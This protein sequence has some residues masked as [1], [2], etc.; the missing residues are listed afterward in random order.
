MTETSDAEFFASLPATRGS[1]GGLI[2]ST[3]GAVLLVRRAYRA[4][5]RWG[6][7]GGIMEHAESPLAACGR[8]IAEELG[9]PAHPLR[10]AVVD[11]MP[12]APPRTAALHWLFRVE[13]S[14]TDF[15]LPPEELSAWEWVPP[16]RLAAYLSTGAARRMAAA[17]RVDDRGSGPVYLENGHPVLAQER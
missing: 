17:V 8:E 7:P 2:R 12:P 11:W 3:T 10:L 16:E 14:S 1:A 9:V 5:G 4:D 6:I 13:V 15:T